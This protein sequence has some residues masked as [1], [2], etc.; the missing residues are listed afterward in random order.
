MTFYL[1]CTFIRCPTRGSNHRPLIQHNSQLITAIAYFIIGSKGRISLACWKSEAY[2]ANLSFLLFFP[3][4]HH[5]SGPGGHLVI[6]IMTPP[7]F[8]MLWFGG[9]T[10][11]FMNAL[12]I[13]CREGFH[14][15]VTWDGVHYCL[16]NGPSQPF[17]T[18]YRPIKVFFLRLVLREWPL[19]V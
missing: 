9:I 2:F 1:I 18:C 15:N 12:L 11:Y 3:I 7:K 5:P 4:S 8:R 13:C 16:L 17:N 6:E 19:L 14:D 10:L